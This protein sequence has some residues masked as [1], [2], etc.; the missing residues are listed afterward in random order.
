MLIFRLLDMRREDKIF[1]T[2][3]WKLFPEFSLEQLHSYLFRNEYREIQEYISY[4]INVCML[5]LMQKN[6]SYFHGNVGI[7]MFKN[8]TVGTGW[9]TGVQFPAEAVWDIF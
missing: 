9:T 8:R 2:E 1:W 7:Y 6:S 5:I 3:K 4:Y